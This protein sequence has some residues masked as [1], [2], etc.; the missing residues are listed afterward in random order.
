MKRA[1]MIWLSMLML[2]IATACTRAPVYDP[3]ARTV[4]RTFDFESG[5][6][7]GIYTNETPSSAAALIQSAIK[8][9]GT[10]AAQITLKP[11]DVLLHGNRSE[12]AIY[13]CAPYAATVF[14]R[15]CFYIPSGDID[16]F[17]WQI[18]S[19]L[20][21]LP[22]FLHG[23]TFELFFQ[24][25]PVDITYVPGYLELKMNVG[26]EVT[27]A[28]TPFPASAKGVWHTNIMEVCLRD[29]AAGYVEWRL[30][31]VPI[32]PANGSTYRYNRATLHNKAGC[33]WKLGIYRGTPGKDNVGVTTTNTIYIDDI[34]IG[35]TLAEVYP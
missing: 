24:H 34:R 18:I 25:P 28:R 5:T 33:Y 3:V 10:Y 11:D 20:Y 19:Q 29:D 14:Y 13:D 2:I 9:S 8:A 22:D 16:G 32:T 23:E 1:T 21:Q 27:A 26:G 15:F 30:D 31:G 12:L 17:R 7:T 6:F 4:P 35:S